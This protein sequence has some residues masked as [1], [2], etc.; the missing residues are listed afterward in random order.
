M[1]TFISDPRLAGGKPPE[2]SGATAFNM[3][4]AL[5]AVRCWWHIALPLGVLLASMAA[6][7]VYYTSKPTY[8][9]VAWLV[10]KSKPAFLVRDVSADVPQK[11]VQNQIELIKSPMVQTPVAGDPDVGRTP[12][13]IKHLDPVQYLRNNI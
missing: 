12:E 5:T 4:M 2:A 11:F 13:L 7:V 6:V 9:A 3:H 1:N 10:I 8:T